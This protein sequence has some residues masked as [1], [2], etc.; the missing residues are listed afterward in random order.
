M[1]Q[2]IILA[3]FV[4]ALVFGACSG[5]S[6]RKKF[7]PQDRTT[8]MSDAQRQEAIAAKK[9]ELNIDPLVMMTTNDVKLTVLPPVASGDIT[10]ELS[11]YIGVKMLGIIAAN[12][13]GGLNS[14]PGFALAATIHQDEKKTTG[15]A[16]QKMITSYTLSYQVM[17]LVTGD[18]YAT[19]SQQITG[20][21]NSFE[22]ATR[23]AIKNIKDSQSIQQMLNKGSQKII[24]WF[25]SNLESFKSQVDAAYGRGDY[26]LC[27]ALIESVPQKA[28]QAFAYAQAKHGEI[29]NKFKA[30]IA[31]NELNA[32]R[33]AIGEAGEEFSKDVY[34]HLSL[35][36]NDSP[37]YGKAQELLS[38]YEA[39]IEK[40]KQ[41]KAS[42]EEADAQR[43]QVIEL[44]KIESERLK[45]LYLA[46]ASEQSIQKKLPNKD[47]VERGFWSK[48]GARII[49]LIDKITS[50]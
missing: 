22:Q 26:A 28:T 49:E 40:A 32:M 6:S 37:Q 31:T 8:T 25:N 21:G 47:Y 10:E 36:P 45:A 19:A 13:I 4:V 34:A 23:N 17:N 12:G 15:T 38:S 48:L 43:R 33:L 44:A 50:L 14:V 11:G 2:I 3:L 42:K 1:N 27:L 16:P 5:D 20:A 39:T 18:V 24:D 46:Q 41:N 29:L 30:Q 7:A 9:S 35:I